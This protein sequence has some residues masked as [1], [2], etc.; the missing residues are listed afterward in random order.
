[1]ADTKTVRFTRAHESYTEGQTADLPTADADRLIAD[2]TAAA[3]DQQAST[4]QSD[5]GRRSTTSTG[6]TGEG[7]TDAKGQPIQPG[8]SNSAPERQQD[9]I[10]GQRATATGA[11]TPTTTDQAKK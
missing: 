7:I 8:F 6:T 2:G 3:V 10:A 1:M 11:R 5:Q 9:G 4:P